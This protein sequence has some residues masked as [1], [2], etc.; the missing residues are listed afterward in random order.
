MVGWTSFFS[1]GLTE[2]HTKKFYGSRIHTTI[3]FE[4]LP[5]LIIQIWYFTISDDAESKLVLVAQLASISSFISIFIAFIDVWSA[6]VTVEVQYILQAN[7][8]QN[9]YLR[10]CAHLIGNKK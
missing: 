9:M 7:K 5:Q 4:N 2:H 1:M 10:L 3:L 6:K 8:S